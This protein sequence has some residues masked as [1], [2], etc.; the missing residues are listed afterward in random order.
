MDQ[1]GLTESYW[2][3]LYGPPP[4]RQKNDFEIELE[5]EFM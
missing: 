4:K 2:N 5:N 3:V 1:S